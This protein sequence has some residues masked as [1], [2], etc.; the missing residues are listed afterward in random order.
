M[1]TLSEQSSHGSPIENT[2]QKY[3]FPKSFPKRAFVIILSALRLSVLSPFF[4]VSP[5]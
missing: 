2:F 1:A 3:E 4:L 5:F